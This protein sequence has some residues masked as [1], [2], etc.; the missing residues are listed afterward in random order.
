[1]EELL[2]KR[3]EID[4]QIR[5]LYKQREALDQEMAAGDPPE[6]LRQLLQEAIVHSEKSF[7]EY[8]TVACQGVEGA[9]SDAAARKL[10]QY[11]GILFFRNFENVFS[12]VE[13]GMCEY[14]ILPIENSTV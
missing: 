9:Y 3:N 4:R 5:Q 11:P 10:F 14:G 6:S 2:A 8:A 13:S 7:P 12:A 1:M